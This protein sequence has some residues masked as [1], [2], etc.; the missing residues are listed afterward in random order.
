MTEPL[1]VTG[2]GCVSALG[3]GMPVFWQ[4]V[5]DGVSGIRPFQLA[6]ETGG[7]VKLAAQVDTQM[8]ARRLPERFVV[9]CDPFAQFALLAAEEAVAAAKIEKSEL[10]GPRTAVI[11]GSGIGGMHTIDD[12]FADFYPVQRTRISPLTIPRLM[13]NAAASIVSMRTGAMGPSFAISAAC[14]SATQS[15]GMGMVLI[16]SGLADRALV[17]GAEATVTPASMRYWEALRVL[18]SDLPR[19]FSRDRSGMALGEGAAV[20][21]IERADLARA[22]GAEILGLLHGF[23][24]SSDAD[25]LVRPRPEG[26]AHAMRLAMADAG[27]APNDIHYINAHGTATVLNDTA[28]TSAVRLA[29]GDCTDRLVMSSTKPIH[30]HV[31]GAAGALEMIATIMAVREGWAPPTINWREA[32]PKCDIDCVANIGRAM[33]IAYAMNNSFAFGGI[34]ASLIVG[35]GD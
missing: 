14:S 12:S 6:R 11:I 34:N 15:I 2:L 16:R 20:L 19:P 4:A 9:Q 32:D 7:H 23:G 22:R 28:E 27:V 8:V 21:L 10:A 30:G 33:P 5:R 24:T 35:P 13:P 26:A 17:G 3:I 18:T 31:L 25:D 1:A 29:F